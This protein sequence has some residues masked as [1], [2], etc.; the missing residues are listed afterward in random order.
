MSIEIA[1]I[2]F[3]FIL[4]YIFRFHFNRLP[5]WARLIVNFPGTV[6]HEICH[7]LVGL[8]TRARPEKIS[9]IPKV[10]EDSILYGYVSFSGLNG[11][12]AF[13]TSMAPL[14]LLLF[15]VFSFYL[16]EEFYFVWWEIVLLVLLTALFCHS[17]IPSSQDFK[18]AAMFPFGSL[19]WMVII[20]WFLFNYLEREIFY[21]IE[22]VNYIQGQI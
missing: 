6:A 15:P 12:N 18:V 1:Y 13:P 19:V 2:L 22:I 4:A 21:L 8:I 20:F 11:F 16:I 10:T 14:L 17:A 9:L 3:S 7:F 5:I